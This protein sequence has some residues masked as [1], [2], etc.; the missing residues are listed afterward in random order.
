MP[1]P[2]D[3][4]T[5]LGEQEKR[6]ALQISPIR[7]VLPF[8]GHR[9]PLTRSSTAHRVSMTLATPA[10]RGQRKVYHFDGQREMAVALEAMLSPEL[11][12][13]EVQ[14]PP[15][16]YISPTG[17]ERSH[18]FDLRITFQGGHRRAVFVRNGKSLSRPE[19]QAEISA[20][21]KA[22]PQSFADDMVVVNGDQYT[23]C[24]RDNLLRIWNATK[25]PDKDLDNYVLERARETSFWLISD[26][27][28]ACDCSKGSAFNAIQRLIGRGLLCV[29]LQAVIS[30]NARIWLA[31]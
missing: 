5:S 10:T 25:S 1:L 2:L 15:V 6:P 17:K 18:S 8:D 23:R 30:Q 16:K 19:A 20:I 26:L 12:G 29:N 24:Y 11:H 28:A 3:W 22:V 21:S 14:L 4:D 31:S 27:V 7:G 9:N 13:L